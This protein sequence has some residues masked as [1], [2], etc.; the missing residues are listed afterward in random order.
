MIKTQSPPA[1]VFSLQD[2][3]DAWDEWGCNCGPTAVAAITGLTLRNVRAHSFE[4]EQKGYTNPRL[5][6]KIL[7]ALGI[8]WEKIE[9]DQFPAYGLARVQWEGP[10]TMPGVSWMAR[11]RHTH[12]VGSCSTCL[13]RLIFDVNAMCVG[14]WISETEWRR[15]MV[16]WLLGQCEPQANGR[17]HLTHSLQITLEE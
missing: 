7:D 17:W 9:A 4:F 2:L 8:T 13:E 12:W 10:W 3:V 14:G 6:Y 1:L 16:P 11:Q 15:D 5:M